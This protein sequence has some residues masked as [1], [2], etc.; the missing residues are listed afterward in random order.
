MNVTIQADDVSR[1]LLAS[2][3]QRGDIV[4]LIGITNIEYF[5]LYFGITQIGLCMLYVSRT[6]S[7]K[8]GKLIISC[9][10]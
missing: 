3:L 5:V 1:A 8:S 2:G 6:F 7:L 9:V 4:F 10:A